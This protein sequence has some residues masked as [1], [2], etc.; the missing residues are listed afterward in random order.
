MRVIVTRPLEQAAEWVAMLRSHRIDAV[1]LPLIAIGAPPD[2]E[3]V[4]K[5]WAM[6]SGRQLVVFVSPNA[7]A[8][9]FARAPAD[10]GWPATARAASPGPGTT[11]ALL[12]FGVPAASIDAPAD[13][14]AQFDSEALWER[15]RERSWQGASVLVV[16]GSRGRDWLARRL[17]DAGATV[18]EL[19]AY[20]R[21]TPV[22]RPTDRDLLTQALAEPSE[23]VW[24]FSSS[25]A[26]ERLAELAAPSTTGMT[27]WGSA[28]AIATHPRIAERARA[29]GFGEVLEARPTPTAVVACI[30]SIRP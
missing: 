1:A 5:A 13:D 24:L 14:A 3:A 17:V 12:D 9:F 28:C 27:Q 26:I 8:S 4:D 21:D 23:H 30:Q 6:L 25:E 20:R 10:G 7:A 29:A 18:D 2:A 22:L 15:L 11:R 19:A 16:R